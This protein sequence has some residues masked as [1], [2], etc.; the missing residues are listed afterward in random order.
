M[1]D[2]RPCKYVLSTERAWPGEHLS[3]LVPA[4]SGPACR[5]A[6]EHG[7]CGYGKGPN[8]SVE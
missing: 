2:A 6:R 4:A 3:W 1:R 8:M 5:A 7:F